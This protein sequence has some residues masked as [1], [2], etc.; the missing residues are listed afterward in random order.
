MLF[1][2]NINHY[3]LL[4]FSMKTTKF[5]HNN[6]RSLH[7]GMPF[8]PAAYFHF[9]N[10]LK[11]KYKQLKQ[12]CMNVYIYLRFGGNSRL[13]TENYKKRKKNH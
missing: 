13:V 1:K 6:H 2:E 4:I 3:F 9:M 10:R 12:I 5:K 7:A 8:S 11:I